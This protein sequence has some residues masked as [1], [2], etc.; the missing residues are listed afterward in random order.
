MNLF[1]DLEREGDH[2][3][4]DPETHQQPVFKD[5]LEFPDNVHTNKQSRMV[6][7]HSESCLQKEW[8]KKKWECSNDS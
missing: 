2:V 6:M 8:Y 4:T 5:T 7:A 3:C 1:S